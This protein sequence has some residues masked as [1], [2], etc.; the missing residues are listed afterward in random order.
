MSEYKIMSYDQTMK[1]SEK[2]HKE[3]LRIA[4][5]NGCFDIVHLG[6]IDYLEKAR[7]LGDK[8][9]VALNTDQS[10]H[11]LKGSQ[12][13]INNEY[14]RARLIA[15]LEF[16]DIVTL[17]DQLTPILLIQ[18]IRPNI[19]VKGGDY[20]IENIIGA[21]FVIENGGDVQIIPIIKGYSTTT[22]IENIRK[23]KRIDNNA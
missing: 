15:A 13:P 10:I 22:L 16:V 12:R 20:T 6:H 4:F 11:Q 17:F 21:D 18:S 1:L 3:G 8:L 9:I 19:L 2:W 14:A 5:T 23:K 7:Q